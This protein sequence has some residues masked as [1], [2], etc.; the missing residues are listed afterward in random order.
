MTTTPHDDRPEAGQTPPQQPWPPAQYG[1]PPMPPANYPPYFPPPPPPPSHRGR[2]VALVAAG[3]VLVAG[4][5]FGAYYGINGGIG[6]TDSHTVTISVDDSTDAGGSCAL[7]N[8]TI[9]LTDQNGTVLGAASLGTGGEP[10]LYDVSISDVP[11]D[12]TQYTVGE[13][14]ITGSVTNSHAEMVS[15]DWHFEVVYGSN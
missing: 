10:C 4:A 5:G 15:T 13:T 9:T 7:D 14:G 2:N 6:S 3:V 11:G 1:P 12:R 8:D